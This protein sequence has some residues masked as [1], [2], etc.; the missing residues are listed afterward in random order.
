M[1]DEQ[2]CDVC[3]CKDEGVEN[4]FRTQ[5][6]AWWDGFNLAK[7]E[8]LKLIDSIAVKHQPCGSYKSEIRRM[9]E[10]L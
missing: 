3:G 5:G 10:E 8:V 7:S 2:K 1:T 9:V 6:E 4:K